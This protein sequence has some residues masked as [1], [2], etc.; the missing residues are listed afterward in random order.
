MLQNG[1]CFS[2]LIGIIFCYLIRWNRINAKTETDGQ[3]TLVANYFHLDPKVDEVNVS[4]KSIPT[5]Q[6]LNE[7]FNV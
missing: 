2:N 3:P 4:F 5:L 7:R 1:V 6:Q